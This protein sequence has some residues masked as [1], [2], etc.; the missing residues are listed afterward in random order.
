MITS[1]N[2]IKGKLLNH[3]A[4]I[5]LCAQ[6]EEVPYKYVSVEGPYTITSSSYGHLLHMATRYLGEKQGYAYA[7]AA[8][9]DDSSIVVTID[10]VTW[11]TVDYAKR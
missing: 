5:S 7:Q 2:S 4:R 8:V 11:Y 10:P 6:S 9:V 1:K 3:A